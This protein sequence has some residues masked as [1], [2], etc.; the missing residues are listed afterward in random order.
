MSI[1]SAARTH[2]G[3]VRASNEDDVLDHPAA[4]LWAVCDG[5]GGHRGGA[6]ASQRLTAALQALSAPVDG[7]AL[8]A[9]TMDAITHVNTALWDQAAAWNGDIS[10]TTVAA[11]LIHGRHYAAVWVGDSRA[12]RWRQGRLQRLTHD[13]SLVQEQIDRGE[14]DAIQ[15]ESSSQRNVLTRAVGAA[16]QVQAEV[17]HGALSPGD[18]FL[19]CSDGLTRLMPDQ[20]IADEMAFS[21]ADPDR[22]CD[23]LIDRCLER[24]APDN[25]SVVAIAITGFPGADAQTVRTPMPIR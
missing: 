21:G 11:L 17:R 13:H 24:G 1:L 4:G 25:V 6:M 10:G 8:L 16:A 12:Y 7:Q 22:M 15:A 18:L 20:E 14:I 5:M 23:R 2:T 9:G 19:L 3:H